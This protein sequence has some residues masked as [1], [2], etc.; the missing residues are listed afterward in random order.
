[1]TR[2]EVAS[3]WAISDLHLSIGLAEEKRKPMDVFDSIWYN[4][5]EKIEEAWRTV[6]KEEDAVLLAGDLFWGNTLEEAKAFFAWLASLPGKKIMARGNH[7]YWWESTQKVRAVLP[8]GIYALECDAIRLGNVTLFGS[9]GYS[10]EDMLGEAHKKK[11]VNREAL[12]LERALKMDG[13]KEGERVVE[14]HYPPFEEGRLLDAYATLFARYA[15]DRVVFGHLHGEEG[16]N[17]SVGEEISIKYDLISADYI[18]FSPK[19]IYN[20]NIKHDR[21]GN[22]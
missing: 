7:D 20:N 21:R 22:D 5:E 8:E 9:K 10:G 12:R 4:H 18:A 17:F 11:M 14:T 19:K 6:V 13:P 2:L 16:R 1:M 3:I 15:V